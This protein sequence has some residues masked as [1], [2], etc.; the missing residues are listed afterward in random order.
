[1]C[2]EE[3]ITI[4]A[5]LATITT[6]LALIIF[7]MQYISEKILAIYLGYCSNRLAIDQQ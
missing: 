6:D 7:A 4:P 2:F 5:F 3:V 1:M